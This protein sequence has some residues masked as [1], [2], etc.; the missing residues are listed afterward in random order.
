MWAPAASRRKYRSEYHANR[1]NEHIAVRL[2]GTIVK[3]HPLEKKK[4][5]ETG[6]WEIQI[7]NV[8]GTYSGGG[9]LVEPRK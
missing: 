6:A 1:S 3:R 7:I 2:S 4:W 5:S 8:K 9:I